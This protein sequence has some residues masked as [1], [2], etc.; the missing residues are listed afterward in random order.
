MDFLLKKKTTG[1]NDSFDRGIRS[2]VLPVYIFLRG[3]DG[4]KFSKRKK[5]KTG[6]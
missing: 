4:P 3:D 1:I 2:Y 6:R 5:T